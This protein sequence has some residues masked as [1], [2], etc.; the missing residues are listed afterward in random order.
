M[1]KEHEKALPSYGESQLVDDF[2]YSTNVDACAPKVRMAFVRKVYAIVTTQLLLT[3]IV[4]AVFMFV[5]PVKLWV[6]ANSSL[7]FLMMIMTFIVM[8]A[9]FLFRRATPWN[10]ILLVIF[11]L[12]EAYV[13]GFIVSV[14]STVLVLEAFMITSGVF[15]GLTLFTFQSKYDFKGL[16]PFLY[17]SLWILILGGLIRIFFPFS[18]GI[19]LAYSIFGAFVF[20]GYVIFDTYMI[21]RVVSAEEYIVAAIN[22]YLD[23]LNLFL[24]I[25]R[26]LNKK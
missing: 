2:N 10:F 26:I 11:T 9:L 17:A 6:H 3:S 8:F 18:S 23:F 4:S 15:I 24:Y 19:D 21:L 13:V 1:N 12:M 16:A 14:Y 25:L 22:L 20:S 7:L 5:E